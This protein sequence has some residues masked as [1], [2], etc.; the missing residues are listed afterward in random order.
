MHG[1]VGCSCSH[2]AVLKRARD[3]EWPNVMILED[4][5][6]STLDAEAWE[7]CLQRFFLEVA[8]YD[9]LL[10][11]YNLIRAAPHG[12]GGVNRTLNAQTTSG[13]VVH[14]CFYD[15]LLD[16]FEKGLAQLK[17]APHKH[18]QFA[19][20]MYWKRLQPSAQWFH[21]A[22]AIGTQRTSYSDIEKKLVNYGV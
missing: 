2:I 6:L 16:N 11:A 21:A 17:K 15:A 13:Y 12:I 7:A 22:P 18:G 5:F 20:D 8:D 9:V 19:L 4:D 10:L 3:E 1:A 14:S